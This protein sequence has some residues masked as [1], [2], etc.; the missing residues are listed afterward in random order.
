[1]DPTELLA[2]TVS[3]VLDLIPSAARVFIAHG[4][5][6]VGC[7]FAPFEDVADAARA[8]GIDPHALAGAL[9][10]AAAAS[11]PKRDAP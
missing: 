4:M 5:G 11:L 10:D 1:V 9:A 8:Y 2:V 3:R 6:C 7:P